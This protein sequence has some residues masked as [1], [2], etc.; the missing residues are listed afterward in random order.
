M[1]RVIHLVT[2]MREFNNSSHQIAA[3]HLLE[4]ALPEELLSIESDWVQCW[5]AD[6]SL[7]D[8]KDYNRET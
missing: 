3:L 8:L 4:E 1:N 2:F 5:L 6:D 7:H